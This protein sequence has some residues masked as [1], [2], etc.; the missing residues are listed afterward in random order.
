MRNVTLTL[1][2]VFA[3]VSGAFAQHMGTPQEQHACS[4]DASRFCR[5][6]LGD[7]MAVQQCLQ[8]HRAKLSKACKGVFESHGM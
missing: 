3:P 4:H 6:S 8:S 1:L 7:D 2:L 5:K